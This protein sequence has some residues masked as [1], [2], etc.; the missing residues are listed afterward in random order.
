MRDAPCPSCEPL[1]LG[2]GKSGG[3]ATVLQ[4]IHN[5]MDRQRPLERHQVEDARVELPREQAPVAE[6]E[7]VRRHA[8]SHVP[9]R[10][11]REHCVK[12]QAR[13]DRHV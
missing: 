13:A 4:R 2:I 10:P 1:A 9:F 8:L 11:W 7:E 6:P 12:F 3:K 5:F